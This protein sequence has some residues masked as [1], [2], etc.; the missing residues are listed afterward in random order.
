MIWSVSLFVPQI[1]EPVNQPYHDRTVDNIADGHRKQI[2]N[3]KFYPCQA[4]IIRGRLSGHGPKRRSHHGFGEYGLR[5]EIH[6]G[7]A[8]FEPCGNVCEYGKYD[9][10]D[11]VGGCTGAVA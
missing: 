4:G 9:A 2:V 8:M 7:H 10:K 3:Q 11:L 1:Y 6:V 5:D